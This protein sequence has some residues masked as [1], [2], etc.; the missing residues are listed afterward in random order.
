M[1]A[2]GTSDCGLSVVELGKPEIVAFENAVRADL[3]ERWFEFTREQNQVE[4]HWVQ[5]FQ[6]IHHYC[7]GPF[8]GLLMGDQVITINATGFSRQTK[9]TPRNWGSYINFYLGYTIPSA[10]GSGFGGSL[11]RWVVEEAKRRG[12]HRLKSL[13]GSEGGFRLHAPLCCVYWGV[14][15]KGELIV[16]MPLDTSANYPKGVPAKARTYAKEA[17]YFPGRPL[18]NEELLRTLTG[19]EGVFKLEQDKA[20]SLLARRNALCV[21]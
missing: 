11:L 10:R 1:A 8:F 4:R 9:K 21:A 6:M 17:Q 7:N 13:V 20:Q 16:D 5:T 19:P 3:R 14:A 12:Y 15:R 2:I 18:S